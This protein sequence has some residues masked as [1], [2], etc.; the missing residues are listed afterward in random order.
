MRTNKTSLRMALGQAEGPL[1]QVG[2]PRAWELQDGASRGFVKGGPAPTVLKV[3]CSHQRKGSR[4]NYRL[5]Q[6]RSWRVLEVEQGSGK[7]WK[8]LKTRG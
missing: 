8:V 2:L 4:G 5:G 7:T 1:E 6:H 3:K